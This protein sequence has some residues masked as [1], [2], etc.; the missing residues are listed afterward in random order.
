NAP[1]YFRLCMRAYE[2]A[3]IAIQLQ[4]ESSSKKRIRVGKSYSLEE[5]LNNSLSCFAEGYSELTKS[6]Q[7]ARDLDAFNFIKR[8]CGEG[9]QFT[10]KFY[11]FYWRLK[12]KKD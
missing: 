10:K 9:L 2:S 4:S 8:F 3:K 6:S 7:R 11:K 12:N 1:E 5:Y